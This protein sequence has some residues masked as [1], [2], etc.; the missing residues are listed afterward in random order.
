MFVASICWVL[1]DVMFDLRSAD[2]REWKVDERGVGRPTVSF[3][4]GNE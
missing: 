2:H 4:T 1:A 3:V